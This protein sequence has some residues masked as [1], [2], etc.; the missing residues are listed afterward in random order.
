[1]LK[2]QITAKASFVNDSKVGDHH[3]IIPTEQAPSYLHMSNEEKKVYDMVV[4]RFLAV[5]YPSCEY[6]ETVIAGM[7]EGEAF[8][9]K[10][11]R[12][13]HRGWKA[14]YENPV[15]DEE[16]TDAE[17][18]KEQTLPQLEK[19]SRLGIDRAEV[20]TGKTKP[21]A[22]FNEATLLS[23][24]E[25]PV[26]YLQTKNGLAAKTLGETGGLGNRGYTGGY[27]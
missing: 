10:G 25:N 14:V 3:A 1:M 8:Y 6:E 4:R 11:N 22:P 9:A 18:V 16:E 26:K 23:A 13:I 21:P 7:I 27:H 19:G 17:S 5:L 15:E 2:K 20:T 24:M 12:T